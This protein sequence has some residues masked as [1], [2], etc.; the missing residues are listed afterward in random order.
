MKPGNGNPF[1]EQCGENTADCAAEQIGDCVTE[2]NGGKSALQQ[3]GTN[4]YGKHNAQ[5][6][7]KYG[8]IV[9]FAKESQKRD[10]D[11]PAA[12]TENSGNGTCG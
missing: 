11:Q 2:G 12:G 6:R 1:C 4:A 8:F 7:G 9:L 5:G 10:K 3:K